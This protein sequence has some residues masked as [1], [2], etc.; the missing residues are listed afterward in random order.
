[1]KKNFRTRLFLASL[2]M[3]LLSLFAFQSGDAP[4]DSKAL[5][6]RAKKTLEP[7]KYD[8]AK[9]TRI[10]YKAQ[11]TQK[12]IEVPLFIGEKYRL[13]FNTEALPKNVVINLYNREKDS[14]KRKLMFST[15]DAGADKKQ[16]AFDYSFANRIFIDYDIPAGDS[17][18]GSG[19]VVFM[20]GYK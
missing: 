4:C 9:I 19:C 6:D 8:V 14:R 3:V 18:A 15:K 13:V 7:Y 1:M 12:E 17:T 11:P 5:K 10:I 16:F 2:S 20:L